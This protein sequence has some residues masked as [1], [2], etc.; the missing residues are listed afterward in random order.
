MKSPIQKLLQ[1]LDTLKHNRKALL[2]LMAIDTALAVSSTVV[3][4]PWLIRVPSH[5]VIFA[6][7]C[8][9]YPFLLLIWFTLYFFKVNIPRWFTAFLY[10][11]LISYGLMS[12]IYFPAYMTWTGINFHDVA[13]MFWV[14]AYGLQAL[15][16]QSEIRRLPWYQYM[17]IFGYFFFK[18]FSDRYLGTFLD[19]LLDSYPEYLKV[20]LFTTVICL[21]IFTAIL[22]LC[23]GK[24]YHKNPAL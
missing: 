10:M 12:W 16:I 4:W 5:L 13:S 11:G 14:A 19:V 2:W 1:S 8:S 7:I 21:H 24:K 17:L 6:P 9:L 22:L 23:L 20:L 18:D 15:I 3:D